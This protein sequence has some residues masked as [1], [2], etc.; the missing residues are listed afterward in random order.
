MTPAVVISVLA[1][2]FTGPTRPTWDGVV[3]F[4]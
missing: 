4:S 1:L 2:A 3:G